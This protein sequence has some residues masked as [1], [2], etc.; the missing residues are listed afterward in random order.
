M[1]KLPDET[2]QQYKDFAGLQGVKT[3]ARINVIIPQITKVVK[4]YCG[5]S[6]VDYY[7]SAKTE[8]FDILDIELLHPYKIKANLFR[9][10][11]TE[12]FVPERNFSIST[13]EQLF[14]ED[15]YKIPN[16]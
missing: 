10:E 6:I 15:P 9:K 2:L 16:K 1:A 12:K 3:D 8:Y 13:I 5:T 7:S 14:V 11:W 4:N